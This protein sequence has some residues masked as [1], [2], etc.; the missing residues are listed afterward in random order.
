MIT[1]TCS[2]C[3]KSKHLDSYTFTLL[4]KYQKKSICKDCIRIS[5][6]QYYDRR[7][8]EHLKSMQSDIKA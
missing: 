5:N 2:K 7:K 8:V 4:G 1:K 6:R 3:K